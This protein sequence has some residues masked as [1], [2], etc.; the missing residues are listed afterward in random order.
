MN[1]NI[2]K[3]LEKLSQD[4]QLAAKF[5][6]CKNA[7]EAYAVASGAVEGFSKE[8]FV[9]AMEQVKAAI[10]ASTTLTEDDISKMAG[11]VDWSAV[12]YGTAASVSISLV[13]VMTAAI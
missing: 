8:E 1:E 11:G 3:F 2:K 7:D 6:A 13:S 9:S 10:D 12:T 4:E 5:D